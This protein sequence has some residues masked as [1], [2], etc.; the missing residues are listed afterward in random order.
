MSKKLDLGDEVENVVKVA[1]VVV[2][3]VNNFPYSALSVV[4]VGNEYKLIEVCFNLET[5]DTSPIKE[6]GSYPTRDEARERFKISI[7]QKGAL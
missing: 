7:V 5:G 6:L 2:A 1:P 3:P 4:H